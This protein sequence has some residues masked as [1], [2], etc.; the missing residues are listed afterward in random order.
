MAT[1]P[2]P[3]Q[4]A[5]SEFVRDHNASG[6]SYRRMAVRATDPQSGQTLG[7][8]WISKLAAGQVA[9]APEPWQMRALAAAMEV[10]EELVKTLAARQWLEYEI[11]EIRLGSDEWILFRLARDLP[12]EDKRMLRRMAEEFVRRQ[13]RRLSEPPD[14]ADTGAP[15][16]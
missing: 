15:S 3:R 7:F 14:D 5:L 10:P 1:T 2:E 13:T 12:D 16:S 9:K 8:Q 4:L 6:L 11:S